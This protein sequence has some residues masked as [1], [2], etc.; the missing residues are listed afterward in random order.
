MLSARIS[1]RLVIPFFTPRRYPPNVTKSERFQLTSHPS[2]TDHVPARRG[3]WELSRLSPFLIGL[4]GLTGLLY[5]LSGDIN[6]DSAWF[7]D[8]TERW[9]NGAE[10]YVDLIE[11]NPPLAFYLTAPVILVAQWTGLFAP[12]VFVVYVFAVIGGS[13]ALIRRLLIDAGDLPKALKHGI[14]LAALFV[15]VAGPL[16]DFGQ[17]EHLATILALPYFVLAAL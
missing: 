12:H 7:L 11:T 15:F 2:T 17:R 8:A 1:T 3:I 14:P 9:L 13:V 10:L 6:H 16:R 4:T 5:Y